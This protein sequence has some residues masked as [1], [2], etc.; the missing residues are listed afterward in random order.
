[1][2]KFLLLI[3]FLTLVLLANQTF[4]Q[5]QELPVSSFVKKKAANKKRKSFKLKKVFEN[6]TFLGQVIKIAYEAQNQNNFD[7]SMNGEFTNTPISNRVL[8]N[9]HYE[10]QKIVI[11]NPF[12]FQYQIRPVMFTTILFH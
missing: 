6:N 1:M 9:S 11:W 12:R 4:A 7:R 10:T 8:Y 2:K 5:E 3:T